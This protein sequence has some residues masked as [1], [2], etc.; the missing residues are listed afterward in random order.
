MFIKIKIKFSLLECYIG[1]EKSTKIKKLRKKE[2]LLVNIGS[3]AGPGEVI[4][5]NKPAVIF[6]IFHSLN[7]P[8]RNLS[9]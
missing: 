3:Y 8:I 4:D 9:N 5:I 2:R 6:L 1:D 7:H